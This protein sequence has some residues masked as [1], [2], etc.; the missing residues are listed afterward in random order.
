M[1]CR[2]D[3][4]RCNICGGE[5]YY[6]KECLTDPKKYGEGL[7]GYSPKTAVE[8]GQKL[9]AKAKKRGEKMRKAFNVEG[10]LC[11]VLTLLEDRR[12]LS[13]VPQDVLVWWEGHQVREQQKIKAAALSKLSTKEKRAL[14]LK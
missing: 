2:V 3:L 9:I 12:L 6:D 5:H 7:P 10:A 14:G 8:K 4:I 13:I 1:P 11:D